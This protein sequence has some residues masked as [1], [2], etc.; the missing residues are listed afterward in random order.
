MK[1]TDAEVA[2]AAG[3]FEGEGTICLYKLRSNPFFALIT[4]DEDVIDRFHEVVG[5]GRLYKNRAVFGM[6]SKQQYVWNANAIN[7]VR[8]VAQLFL[9]WLGKRRRARLLEVLDAYNTAD[10]KRA[11][12]KAVTA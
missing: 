1:A 7:E 10:V 12:R 3:L 8:H 4:T 5:V 11:P 6:G 2:W 9:P